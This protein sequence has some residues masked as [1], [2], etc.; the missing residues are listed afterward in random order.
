VQL[1]E[2]GGGGMRHVHYVPR[3]CSVLSTES[4]SSDHAVRKSL[5]AAKPL[6]VA[7]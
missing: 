2:V 6:A 4:A 7:A 5:T 1:A 3:V